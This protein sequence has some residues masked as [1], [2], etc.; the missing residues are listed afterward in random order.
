MDALV[1]DGT[2][3]RRYYEVAVWVESTLMRGGAYFTKFVTTLAS[4]EAALK[5]AVREIRAE[6]DPEDETIFVEDNEIRE[7]TE[8]EW[9]EMKAAEKAYRKQKDDIERRIV[10][11]TY[12]YDA[13]NPDGSR[14]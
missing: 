14:R 6:I 7:M 3:P 10:E 4:P 8:D 11:S 9:L 12:I 1:P 13:F 5:I 2:W